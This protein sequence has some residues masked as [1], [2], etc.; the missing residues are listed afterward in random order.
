[1]AQNLTIERQTKLTEHQ[2]KLAITIIALI[3]LNPFNGRVL[4]E[5]NSKFFIH[6]EGPQAESKRTGK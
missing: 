5:A 1:M 6:K 3:S 2:M 4:D